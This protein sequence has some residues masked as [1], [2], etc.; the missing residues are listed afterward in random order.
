MARSD[1]IPERRDNL[2]P[3]QTG[4]GYLQARI[5]SNSQLPVG[6]QPFRMTVFH[7]AIDDAKQISDFLRDWFRVRRATRFLPSC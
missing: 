1:A 7:V 3:G 6:T 5:V 2:P 4:K